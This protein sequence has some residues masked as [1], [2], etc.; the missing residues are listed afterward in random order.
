M[1]GRLSGDSAVGVPKASQ[2]LLQL[3]RPG[4]DSRS[5][6]GEFAFLPLVDHVR[7]PGGS[8]YDPFVTSFQLTGATL[9]GYALE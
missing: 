1:A 6:G 3:S 8:F 9:E 2:V 5:F 7:E 4:L